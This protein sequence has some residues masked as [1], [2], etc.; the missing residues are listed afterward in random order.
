MLSYQEF[1]FDNGIIIR[2][3]CELLDE[4]ISDL[5]YFVV[6]DNKAKIVFFF[7][8]NSIAHLSTMPQEEAAGYM[9]KA[10]KFVFRIVSKLPY[11]SQR[12]E[13]SKLLVLK[14]TEKLFAELEKGQVRIN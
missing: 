10:R 5:S 12:A 1:L 7:S 2:F 9:R 3:S 13:F 11:G 6:I 8:C 14:H 4:I